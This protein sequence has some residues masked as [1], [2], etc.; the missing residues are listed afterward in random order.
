MEGEREG[1][2]RD[3]VSELKRGQPRLM[4]SVLVTT[5]PLKTPRELSELIAAC[6]QGTRDKYHE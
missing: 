3:A 6:P 5:A 4:K 1:E 2:E